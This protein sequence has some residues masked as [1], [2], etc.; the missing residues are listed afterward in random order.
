MNGTFDLSYLDARSAISP[1]AAR[2]PTTSAVGNLAETPFEGWTERSADGI[3]DGDTGTGAPQL[4]AAASGG[5]GRI[6]IPVMG[7]VVGQSGE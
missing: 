7:G 6:S 5:V 3:A 1:A 2:P 4:A